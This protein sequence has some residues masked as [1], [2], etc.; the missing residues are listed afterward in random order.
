MALVV[1][2]EYIFLFSVIIAQVFK[3]IINI[4][5]IVTYTRTFTLREQLPILSERKT[6]KQ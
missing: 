5:C 1:S 2:S 4:V 3:K 6:R